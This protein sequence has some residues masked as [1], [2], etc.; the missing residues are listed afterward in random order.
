MSS[1]TRNRLLKPTVWI[2]CLVPLALLIL[3]AVT[4]TLG[5]NP[6]ERITHRTGLATLVLLLCGL[7]ITPLRRWT[8]LLWLIQYRRL[9][10][11]FAFFYGCLHL[12]TYLWLDQNF[13]I[14]AMA[15]DVVK[16]P[17]ITVGTLAW[18]LLLPLAL[19]ST[20]KSIR[21]LGKN[22]VR[23]HR[24]V[25]VAAAAGAIHFYWL[26]KRDKREPLIYLAVL[27]VLLAWRVAIWVAKNQKQQKAAGVM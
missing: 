14:S 1:M 7:A 15:H 6:V 21:S 3:G 4:G 2:A 26:V 17:F 11:L 13:S 27:A 18:L 10:G 16:R 22:W 24:L 23:L 9:V 12:L 19:T 5:A 20:Q 25:Y 8:G